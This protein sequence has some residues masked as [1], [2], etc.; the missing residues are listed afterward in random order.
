MPGGL[1]DSLEWNGEQGREEK[2]VGV[3][4]ALPENN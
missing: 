3:K 4:R 1:P 2:E